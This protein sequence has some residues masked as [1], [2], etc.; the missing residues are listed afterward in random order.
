MGCLLAMFS[1]FIICYNLSP[2]GI[3]VF[4]HEVGKEKQIPY[5]IRT[6]HC[7]PNLFVRDVV[8]EVM[9]PDEWEYISKSHVCVKWSNRKVEDT[10]FL[11]G[12]DRPDL[13]DQEGELIGGRRTG[14]LWMELFGEMRN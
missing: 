14:K 7:I 13:E 10:H 4:S 3:T 2:Q 8:D 6:N 9:L 12:D 5:D 11:Y 1:I